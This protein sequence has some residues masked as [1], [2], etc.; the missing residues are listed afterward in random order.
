MSYDVT[1]LPEC[2][3]GLAVGAGHVTGS[4]YRR[5]L[6]TMWE[7]ERWSREFVEVWDLS[8]VD[9]ID[10]TPD[11]VDRIVETLHSHADRLQGSRVML[12]SSR[13]TVPMLVRLFDRLTSD[14]ART[15]HVARTREE[16]AE[17]L[18]VPLAAL[19]P[20]PSDSACV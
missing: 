8:S 14:I 16:A 9:V 19:Y 5:A 12:I 20:E 4:D 11:D 13:D 3:V 18:G 1:I 2:R 6:E 10:V 15:Y 17:W 7:D